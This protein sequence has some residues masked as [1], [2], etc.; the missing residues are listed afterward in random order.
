[1]L[2]G[3]LIQFPLSE[4]DGS[5]GAV[6]SNAGTGTG[7]SNVAGTDAETSAD[8]GS[9]STGPD[10][11]PCTTSDQCLEGQICDGET[12]RWPD[13]ICE[14]DADC[15]GDT[16]CCAAGCLPPGET[17]GQCIPHPPGAFDDGC[18]GDIAIGLFEPDL[19]CAWT[20]PAPTDPL[21]MHANVLASAIAVDL[22]YDSGPAGELLVS[23][24]NC[25]DTANAGTGIDPTCFGV[26]RILNAQTCELIDTLDDPAARL[27]GAAPPAVADLDGDASPEI[28]GLLPVTGVIALTWSPRGGTYIPLWTATESDITDE[29][30]WDGVS[31]HDIDD[32][33]APEVI[34][35]SEVYDGTTGQRRNPGQVLALGG[36]MVVPVL[37]DFVGDGTVEM[38]ADHVFFW[39][40]EMSRWELAHQPGGGGDHYAVADFGT[41]G[42]TPADFDPTTLDGIPEVV[43]VWPGSISIDT[44]TAQRVLVVNAIS[45]GGPPTIANFDDDPTPEIG[46]ANG[47]AYQVFDLQCDGAPVGCTAPFVRWSQPSTEVQSGRTASASFDF[48]ADQRSEVVYADECYSRIYDGPTGE[49]LY[50]TPRRACTWFDN[51]TVA[52]VDHDD[53]TELVVN[54]ND[55]CDVACDDVD[56]LHAGQRCTGDDGCVSNRCVEGLC[57]CNDDSECGWATACAAPLAG[58]RGAGNTCRA[59]QNS[60]PEQHGVQVLRDRLDRWAPARQLWNQHAYTVTHINDDLTVPRSSAWNQNFHDPTLNNYRH[61]GPGEAD[62]SARPDI[63]AR[64]E[65]VACTQAGSDWTLLA[66]VCNRGART[67]GAGLPAS[68][69]LGEDLLCVAETLEPLPPGECLE[70]SCVTQTEPIGEVTVAGNTDAQGRRRAIECIDTNGI[71]IA[72]IDDCPP[73]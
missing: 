13:G 26:L 56:P 19:Q 22:P 29:P 46:S 55:N 57:R 60:E 37:A 51:P 71:D 2:A 70:I 34:S 52:D 58:T 61:N 42:A 5:T 47:D 20:G 40:D 66:T 15:T 44:L 38:V 69:S 41:P 67:A 63:T 43:S 4:Q 49:V 25:S 24:Y 54:F 72:Q 35:G 48:D 28:V 3:C 50:S 45:G 23:T 17:E 21:P 30:R 8:T 9:A 62:P 11:Q 7:S 64:F 59:A 39:S 53:Q 14:S 6:T 12:C 31:I 73:G 27:I 32:D 16:F 68:F 18:E 1:M 36:A 33:G 10:G 65:P